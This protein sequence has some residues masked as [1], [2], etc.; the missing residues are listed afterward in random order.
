MRAAALC[1][2]DRP[3]WG[4]G[5]CHPCYEK[6]VRAGRLAEP[7]TPWQPP[8]TCE[9]CAATFVPGKVDHGPFCGKRCRDVGRVRRSVPRRRPCST[10]GCSRIGTRRLCEACRPA[11]RRRS[12]HD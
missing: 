7:W 10:P 3:N 4:R 2:A 12:D 8:R 11:R 9:R 5:M 6:A 1:H